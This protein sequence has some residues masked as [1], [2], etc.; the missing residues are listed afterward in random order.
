MSVSSAAGILYVRLT[1]GSNTLEVEMYQGSISY[2]Y[3]SPNQTW[4][5]QIGMLCS[6]SL[7][8][9]AMLTDSLCQQL[10]HAILVLAAHPFIVVVFL[11]AGKYLIAMLTY[12][13]LQRQQTTS[14]EIELNVT[15]SRCRGE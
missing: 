1:S 5:G 12:E 8:C 15:P 2:V 6:C 11:L 13:D 9:S 10:F 4:S 3:F 7:L 14:A